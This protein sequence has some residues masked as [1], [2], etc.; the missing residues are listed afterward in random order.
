MMFIREGDKMVKYVTEEEA[1]KIISF[2]DVEII[3]LQEE[4]KTTRDK[5]RELLTGLG[6][7]QIEFLMSKSAS[8]LNALSRGIIERE[9]IVD[10]LSRH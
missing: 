8:F 4:L 10:K 1:N 3:G 6:C 9:K 5:L 7:E 2:K